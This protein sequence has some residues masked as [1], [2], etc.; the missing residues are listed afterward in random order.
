MISEAKKYIKP[1]Y[2]NGLNGRMLNMPAPKNK[3][4]EIL[5][6]Y[7]HHSS[8]ERWYGLAED[9]NQYGAI[10]IPD[11]PGFGG[12]DSFH[13]I[14]MK[15]SLDNLADYLASFVKMRYKRKKVTI[16]GMSL[17]FVIVTRML[18]R[19][20]ELTS[21]VDMLVSV[22]GF[23]HNDSFTFTKGRRSFYKYGSMVFARKY[24]ALFFHNVALHPTILR[25][26]YSKTHNAKKKFAD[27][28]P[29]EKRD[30][31]EFEVFLWR[32]NEVR[33]YM[34]T[35]TAMLTLDNLKVHIPLKLWHITVN[36]DRY[37]DGRVV[38][39]HL[40]IIY[41]DVKVVIADLDNHAPTVIASKEA[42]ASLIPT[43]LRRELN[44]DPK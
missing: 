5:F 44:K 30:A 32:N 43:S 9:L 24:P 7:G 37:F 23:A 39:Q 3:K 42:T 20:P 35:T 34:S 41:D 6:I 1:L 25:K 17:G 40:R 11:L 22:V 18:Q 26:F 31:T 19:Y 36:D 29:Q 38:E 12:M 16:A 33:T 15:P 4:R 21:K 28:S 8:L 2:I 27:L 14:G 10:T 13:K